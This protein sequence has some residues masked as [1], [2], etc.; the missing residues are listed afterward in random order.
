MSRS[1][2]P[3]LLSL[4]PTLP[5]AESLP[6]QLVSL[7]AS[8]LAQSRHNASTLKAEEEVARLY[9]CAHIACE[10]LK[11]T[12][13]LPPIQARPPVPPRIY[14]RLYT[15][16]DHILPAS[17]AAKSGRIR[18][19]SGKAREAGSVFGSG[20]AL[21]TPQRATPSKESALAQF[22]SK[23]DHTPS[24]ST[25]KARVPSTATK[26]RNALP[27]WAPPTI[28]SVC[29]QLD[30]ERIAPTVLAGFQTI[31][32]PHGKRTKDSWVNEHLT[33]LLAAVFFL[34]TV[35]FT[36]L[37][38]GKPIKGTQFATVRKDVV[39]ALRQARNDVDDKAEDE[40]VFWDG[41]ANVG[42]KDVDEAAKKFNESGWQDEEWFKG[43]QDQIGASADVAMDDAEDHAAGAK[44]KVQRGDT[45]LQGRWLMDDTKRHE[46][47]RWKAEIL[48]R[49]DEVQKGDSAM[50]VNASA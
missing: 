17:S 47:N 14:K 5:S 3:T 8:L 7:S 48:K 6:Q 44:A 29:K 13:D 15:H 46:Y 39:Q 50:H 36:V 25:G 28:R 27:P 26:S 43:I 35:R 31:V 21:R 23:A 22:R 10:R 16:L 19:P 18:T 12:L 24:K 11:T 38:S 1:V 30:S 20:S 37:V 45:M 42:P 2:E 9:A 41:W 33:P 4:L 40:E 32:A 49:C 34:V